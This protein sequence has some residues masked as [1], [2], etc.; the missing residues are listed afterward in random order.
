[1]RRSFPNV[2]PSNVKDLIG[3][4]RSQPLGELP[5]GLV[6]LG[7]IGVASQEAWNWQLAMSIPLIEASEQLRHFE[8][9]VPCLIDPS[10]GV[11]VSF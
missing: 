2:F 4:R 8:G 6:A 7:M 1:L 9:F 5:Y 11:Q 3:V 10:R